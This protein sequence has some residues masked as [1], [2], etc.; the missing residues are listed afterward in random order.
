MLYC[1]HTDHVDVTVLDVLLDMLH[2]H[3][4]MTL[5]N[6]SMLMLNLKDDVVAHLVDLMLQDCKI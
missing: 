6:L 3:L 2:E 1:L 4:M 5:S